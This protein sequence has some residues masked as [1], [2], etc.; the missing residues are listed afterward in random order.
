MNNT[1]IKAEINHALGHDFLC[2]MWGNKVD[3]EFQYE[4]GIITLP[5]LEEVRREFT[6]AL[7]MFLEIYGYVLEVVMSTLEDYTSVPV[8]QL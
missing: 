3:A 8:I 7:Q 6:I 4:L 1:D 2:K 5:R